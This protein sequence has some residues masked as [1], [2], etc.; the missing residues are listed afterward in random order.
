[1][2]RL[3]EVLG[4]SRSQLHAR[5]S[6]R[7]SPR[8]PYAKS[9]DAELLPALR[10]LVDARPTY[11]YRRIAALLNRDRRLAGFPSVNRKRVLRIL[12]K[13][14]LTLERCTGRREGAPMTAKW[15]SWPQTC[16]RQWAR[17]SGALLAHC[18]DGLEIVC[19]NREKVRIALDHRSRTD[20]EHGLVHRCLRSRDRR[21]RGSGGSR[22]PRLGYPR[23]DAGCRRTTLRDRSGPATGGASFRQRQ[24]LHRKGHAR[25]GGRPRPG[26]M[27]HAR[28]V[29]GKQR[30]ERGLRENPQA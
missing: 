25:L 8:G 19:W 29:T 22:H 23:H 18:S 17:T 6:G 16:V 15:R 1:M 2:R 7:S 12:G 14:G 11:G 10:G 27:L 9:S 13:H 28:P 4:V 24:L 21:S 20:G 5:A 3:A 30:H 26:S